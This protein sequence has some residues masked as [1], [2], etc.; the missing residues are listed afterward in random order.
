M[1]EEAYDGETLY[2][3]A[4]HLFTVRRVD[5]KLVLTAVCGTAG[6]SLASKELTL[7]EIAA[8]Q[9]DPELLA[10]AARELCDQW[11]SGTLLDTR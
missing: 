9:E 8:F 11:A 2:A 10:E 5:G 3:S 7:Q 1:R 4:R 6:L